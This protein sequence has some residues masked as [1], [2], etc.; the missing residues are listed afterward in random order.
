MAHI[1]DIPDPKTGVKSRTPTMQ[2][3]RITQL[4]HYK[5]TITED[6]NKDIVVSDNN[7]K[8][9]IPRP[10]GILKCIYQYE[11]RYTFTRILQPDTLVFTSHFES[12]NLHSAHRLIPT[13]DINIRHSF[14]DLY[15]HE[16][17]NNSNGN[18]QWFYFGVSNTRAYQTVRFQLIP[19]L[20]RND[21]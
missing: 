4:Q 10:P 11:D 9:I 5:D 21:I 8:S 15:L 2:K 1:I 7:L 3:L 18:I 6:L 12:G 20:I 17:I 19:I 13:P 14:Y 16:D